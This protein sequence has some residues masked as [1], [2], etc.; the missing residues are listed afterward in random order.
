MQGVGVLEV[1]DGEDCPDLLVKKK[2]GGAGGAPGRTRVAAADWGPRLGVYSM[3]SMY[4][5]Y[6]F[7]PE[8]CCS[9]KSM[10]GRSRQEQ[11]RAEF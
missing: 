3:Y 8:N 9:V 2:R 10:L 4:M 1:H 5:H 11:L 6:N 7:L